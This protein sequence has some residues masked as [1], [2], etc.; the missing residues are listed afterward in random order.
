M[1]QKDLIAQLKEFA[2]KRKIS[3]KRLAKTLGIH[4]GTLSQWLQVH[5]KLRVDE[6]ERIENFFK[7]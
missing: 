7:K 6:C 2:E 1:A 4:P 5:R 3:H